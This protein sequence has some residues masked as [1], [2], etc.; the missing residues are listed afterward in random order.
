M[1]D[2][3]KKTCSVCKDFSCGSNDKKGCWCMDIELKD[4]SKLEEASDCLCPSCSSK[5]P[6]LES[7]S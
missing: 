7:E 1:T 2:I 6:S 5:L 4:L 3:L